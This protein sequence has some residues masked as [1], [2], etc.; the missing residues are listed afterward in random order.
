MKKTAIVIGAT[1]LVG[2]QL[3]QQLLGDDRFE[4][5]VIFVRRKSG[6]ANPKLV[7]HI[8]DFNQMDHWKEQIRGDILFSALGTTLKKAGSKQAQFKIDY[9]YQYEV[10]EAAAQ[11][12]VSRYVLISSAGASPKSKIFYSRMKGEL[13]EAVQKLSF[14]KIAILRPSF[15]NG[16]RKEERTGEKVMLK[17][18]RWATQFAFKKYRPIKDK[19]VAKAMIHVALSDDLSSGKFM[20]ELDEIF[21]L[22]GE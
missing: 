5:V 20:Y 8:V 16:D 1:G 3:V 15:L 4:K 14:Q 17:I 11:N 13:D 7:E 10:A 6:W 21:P 9:T 12:G 18:S 2:S 22:A 19:T